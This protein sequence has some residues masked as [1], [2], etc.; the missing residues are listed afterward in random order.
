[1]IVFDSSTIILLAKTDILELFISNFSGKV[2]IP[3]KVKLEVYIEGREETPLIVKLIKDKKIEVIRAKNSAQ[4]KK[5]IEDFNIDAGEAE[6]LTLAIQEG[7]SI[8]ATDDRNAIRACKI[9]KLDFV[10]ATAILIRAFEKDLIGRDEALIKLQKLQSIGRYN[11]T[12]I[13]DAT[14]Q[15][16]GGV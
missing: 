2:L 7:A 6:V 14:K 9:L 5:L 11:S 3:E 13:K 1:M 12:I 4:I 16:K 15:I 10:T 8:I